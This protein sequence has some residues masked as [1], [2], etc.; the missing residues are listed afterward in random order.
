M[1]IGTA[2]CGCG[3]LVDGSGQS[4][5]VPDTATVLSA[6]TPQPTSARDFAWLMGVFPNSS[7]ISRAVGYSVESSGEPE[8][9]GAADLRDTT[10]LSRVSAGSEC[11]GVAAPLEVNTYKPAPVVAVSYGT[12]PPVTA[13]TVALASEQDAR[14]LF[15]QM[16]D[17][18]RQCAGRTL[19]R[20]GG[21]ADTSYMVESVDITP[22]ILTA[23]VALTPPTG[24]V[25]VRIERAVG[26]GRECV[27]DVEVEAADPPAD[28]P[29]TAGA[30]A[31][32]ASDMLNAVS[33]APR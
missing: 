10:V 30:A 33:T 2:L 14:A 15:A 28:S 26:I 19:V 27:V 18:W 4:E 13:G 29:P 25:P 17:Q 16:T 5:E 32:L 8:V 23:V 31:A 12:E 3:G 21:G 1:S 20:S 9:G 6:T 22:T 11:L 7:E 24:G